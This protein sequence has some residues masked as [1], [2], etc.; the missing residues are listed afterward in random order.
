MSTDTAIV[1]REKD[2]KN[3]ALVGELLQASGLFPDIKSRA[4]AA[5]K[6]LAGRELGLSP[7]ESMRS[8]HVM[9]GK[10]ELSAD[11]L[12]QRVKADPRYDY[13]VKHL[14]NERAEIEFLQRDDGEH[15]IPQGTSVFTLE[16]A[17]TAILRF[18][19]KD[20]KP[21]P[22]TTYPRNMLFARAMSN[23]VAWF[24]PDVVGARVYVEGEIMA[25]DEANAYFNPDATAEELAEARAASS[26]VEVNGRA[27]DTATGEIL[28]V[29]AVVENGPAVDV[30]IPE[31]GHPHTEADSEPS[32]APASASP[33]GAREASGLEGGGVGT[34]TAPPPSS[35]RATA[36]QK[37]TLAILAGKLGWDDEQRHAEARVASFNDLDQRT[38]A[39]LVRQWDGLVAAGAER[40]H[41][42]GETT[43]T[44]KEP[45]ATT[46][47][48]LWALSK[49]DAR[50]EI[51]TVAG[52]LETRSMATGR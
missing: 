33:R 50:L 12:A 3:L 43:D 7:V 26:T 31:A 27:V 44:G 45:A 35:K 34:G 29:A 51:C 15:W 47:V 28:D 37:A 17:K 21:T 40:A 48:H 41:T 19:S 25:D 23:G 8:L 20:G 30:E 18:V 4:Q 5:V 6:V 52:C 24:C 9:D 38:A 39:E 49:V 32:V 42:V 16:D 10:V 1:L 22:W 46:H 2:L 14:D 36:R 13:R 11:L